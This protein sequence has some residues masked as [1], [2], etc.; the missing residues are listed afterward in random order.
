MKNLILAA[1]CCIAIPGIA[2]AAET[3]PKPEKCCCEKMKEQGKDCCA[4]MKKDDHQDHSTMQH[5]HQMD[6]PK[7]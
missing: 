4:E 6:A 1:A 7:S 3:A 2:F 5:D